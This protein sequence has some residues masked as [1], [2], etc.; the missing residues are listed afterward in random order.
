MRSRSLLLTAAAASL[1][2]LLLAPTADAA[3]GPVVP[4]PTV[5]TTGARPAAAAAAGPVVARMARLIPARVTAA[6]AL[7]GAHAV[8]VLDPATGATIWSTAAGTPMRGAS[9]T[10]LATAVT[11]LALLGTGTRFPTRV[12]T[13]RND[14]EVVLVAGGDPMLTSGQLSSLATATAKALAAALPPPP[15]TPPATPTRLRIAVTVDDTLYGPATLASGWPADYTPVVV[16]PVRPLVRDLRHSS[17]TSADATRYFTA[18][19]SAALVAVL[20]TRPDL[21]PYT[22]YTGRLKAS[23]TAVELARF[24]GNTSGAALAHMLVVS[25]NDTAERLFR[26]NAV[27][28]GKPGTWAGAAAA[29]MAVLT[30]LGADVRGFSIH[31]GSGVSRNDRVTARGLVSL[32]RLAISPDH[33]EL[34]PLR[35]YLPV[36]GVSGTLA[37]RYRSKPTRCAAGRVFAKTGTL[38]DAIGLAGYARGSDG[39]L[40]LFAVLDV[41]RAGFSQGSTRAAVDLVP[42]TMTGCY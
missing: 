17:D 29:E 10:K 28:Q 1:G 23:A 36:A 5:P 39:R 6:K 11:S 37:S 21:A 42:T 8:M 31:D 27:A 25:D 14:H 20:K 13:G 40:R 15:A 16:S 2:A 18:R 35:G 3:P 19:L 22:R 12:V 30:R 41:P 34:A 7:R 24:R 38:H 4:A 26:D 9:T 33:P 32:L